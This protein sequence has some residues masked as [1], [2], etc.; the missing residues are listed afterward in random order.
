MPYTVALFGEAEKGEFRTAYFCRSLP[1]LADT[2]GHPPEQS[3]GLHFAVQVLMHE[4]QLVFFRVKE[5]GYSEDD[6][7][8]GLR[9]LK[10]KKMFPNLAAIGLPGVGEPSIYDATVPICRMYNG[11]IIATESDLYDYLTSCGG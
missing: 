6:Y 9:F 1:Q 2:L 4:H 11:I 8:L 5:E 3:Q 10:N 7:V